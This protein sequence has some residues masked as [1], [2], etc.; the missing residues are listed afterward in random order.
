V[1][2]ADMQRP[3]D[4]VAQV[5]NQ[6]GSCRHVFPSRCSSPLIMGKSAALVYVSSVRVMRP[7]GR[8]L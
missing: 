3:D 7:I 2:L 1:Q 8:E 4:A 6:V 5:V